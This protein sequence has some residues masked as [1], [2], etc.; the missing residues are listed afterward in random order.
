M[1]QAELMTLMLATFPVG[2]F[3][4]SDFSSLFIFKCPD[5]LQNE[6]KKKKN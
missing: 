3:H 4:L 5:Y 1:R 2:Q 6:T